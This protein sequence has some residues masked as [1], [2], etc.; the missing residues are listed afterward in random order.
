MIE[1]GEGR[2][3]VMRYEVDC[4]EVRC[5]GLSSMESGDQSVLGLQS[6]SQYR[7]NNK[8]TRGQEITPD[9]RIN[10]AGRVITDRPH[11]GLLSI[12]Q[13]PDHC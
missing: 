11:T 2:V 5:G 13:G 10:Q 8:D 1:R 4:V 9:T 3:F 12:K 6:Q 7:Y